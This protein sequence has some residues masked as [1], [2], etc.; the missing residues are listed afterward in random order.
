M[1]GP[2]IS[3]RVVLLRKR[4]EGEKALVRVLLGEQEVMG[5]SYL[6]HIRDA[7]LAH[8]VH[9]Q[10]GSIVSRPRQALLDHLVLGL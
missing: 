1:P 5:L 3:S 4:C 10:L 7:I 6:R 2:G 9:A 8:F